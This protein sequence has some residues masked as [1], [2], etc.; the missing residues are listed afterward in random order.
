MFPLTPYPLTPI[1]NF[2]GFVLSVVPLASHLG[3]HSCRTGIWMY[4]FWVGSQNFTNFVDSIIWRNNVN[5]VAPVWC[6]IV[7]KL[8]LGTA[9]GVPGCT[10]VFCR[11]LYNIT[12]IRAVLP[13]DEKSE[14][15]RA[16]MIDLMITL[17]VPLASMA[18]CTL[19]QPYRFELVE[20]I[21]CQSAEFSYITFGMIF[22]LSFVATILAPF[23]IHFFIRHRAEVNENLATHPEVIPNRYHRVMAIACLTLILDLPVCVLVVTT[24]LLAGGESDLNNPYR[25]W[26]FVRDGSFSQIF[27]TT[28]KEW[29]SDKWLVFTVKW[30]EWSYVMHAIVFFIIFGT[31][32]EARTRY[33][34]VYSYV[35]SLFRPGKD[36]HVLGTSDIVFSSRFSHRQ[37]IR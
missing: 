36:G 26:S 8:Q 21:G 6:D 3:S 16:I 27:Q 22:V 20:E 13:V 32:L 19:T 7:T 12:R 1:G 11:H 15:R 17:G 25:S 4:A 10:L 35:T 5:I 31:T 14:R 2:I 37:P 24:R 23:P 18:L 34:N 33:W 28:A 9:V 30:N 29:G